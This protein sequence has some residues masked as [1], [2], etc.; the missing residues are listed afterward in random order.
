[1]QLTP[2]AHIQSVAEAA[3]QRSHNEPEFLQAMHEVL[4][5]LV[6]VLAEHPEFIEAA[7]LERL[8]EPE[9]QILFRVPWL[10][11]QNRVRVNRGFR[12][13]FNSA[14]G[15]FKG[16]LR[17]HSSVNLSV[18][19]FLGFEQIFKNAL[20]RQRIGGAK[21]GSDFDPHGKSDEE[22]MRF[23]QSF[24][25]ELYRY[26]GDQT[27]VP[28]GDI[29]V[30]GREIGYLFGQY[31]RLTGRHESGVLT[32]KGKGW[33][34]AEV[35]T[36]ATGYG[37]V[38][39]AQEMLKRT[40]EDIDGRRAVVSGSGNVAIYAIEKVSQLG[41]TAVTAS[42]SSGYVVDEQGIDVELLKQI[43]EVE[44]GRISDYAERKPGA[45]FVSGGSVWDVPAELA[46]PCATQNELDER[47]AR[48]LLDGGVRVVA[49]G[50][51][52]PTT[53]EAVTL[54]QQS[55]ILFGPGKAANSGGVATSA[56][57]MSQNAA[58][59]R[60]D[61]DHSEARLQAIMRDVHDASYEASERYGRPGDYVLGANSAGFVTV[62]QAMI[63]QGLV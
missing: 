29:G 26:I 25:T 4:D 35:R 30:G 15:P 53:P 34:G 10:D 63:E 43:K 28:A 20:T 48:A 11:D 38:F 16:G 39:F 46:F 54:L 23:C 41:G 36:E 6:P 24:M 42:D 51:N 3:A 8:V 62:A 17:F 55:G 59:D 7:V 45:R 18:V 31:R 5:T 56:L 49:E 33:G 14:L 1:M 58:R 27:D 61:F 40:G 9:R 22:V 52:M 21:G 32:G 47:G 60:W 13:Q 19:K 12:V 57:E 44:R 37:A 2:N 50:A